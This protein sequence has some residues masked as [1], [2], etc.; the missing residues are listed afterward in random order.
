MKDQDLTRLT[1]RVLPCLLGLM[2]TGRLL[3]SEPNAKTTSAPEVIDLAPVAARAS[4]SVSRKEALRLINRDAGDFALTTKIVSSHLGETPA[5][6][7]VPKLAE[8]ELTYSGKELSAEE[9]LEEISDGRL[10]MRPFVTGVVKLPDLRPPRETEIQKFIR[11]GTISEHV[12][13]TIT[14]RLWMKGDEG[15]ML[16]FSW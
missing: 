6:S 2:I 1:A 16:R 3:G 15:I 5:E 4:A 8:L 10:K 14:T 7:S 11:T 12:G 9:P 13:E